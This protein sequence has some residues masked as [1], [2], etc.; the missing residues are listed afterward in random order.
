MKESDWRYLVDALLFICL[1]GMTLIGILLGLVIP[2]GP[3]SSESAKY[4]LALHRHQW[5]NI[6]AYLSIGFVVLIIVHIVLNWKWITAKTSQIFRRKAAPILISAVSVPFLVLVVFWAA[7]PKDAEQYREYG[8][9]T[10]ERGR[11]HKI[12]AED[13]VPLA[14]DTPGRPEYAAEVESRDEPAR[15]QDA[16]GEEDHGAVGSVVISGRQTLYDIERATG[17]PARSIADRLGLP[18]SASLNE[19]LG[20][21]RRLYG[22]EIQEVREVVDQMLKE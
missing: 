1:G 8:I 21:L 9:E 5:G 16:P 17:L 3:V 22:F 10:V 18:S 20:R 14:E 11:P 4:F 6:H 7:T 15:R 19:T 12:S 2:A 13:K